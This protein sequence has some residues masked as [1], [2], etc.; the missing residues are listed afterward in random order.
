[1]PECDGYSL[2]VRGTQPPSSQGWLRCGQEVQCVGSVRKVPSTSV[3]RFSIAFKSLRQRSVSVREAGFSKRCV[4]AYG[5]RGVASVDGQSPK[6]VL[7]VAFQKSRRVARTVKLQRMS[8]RLVRTQ[9]SVSMASVSMPSISAPVENCVQNCVRSG[10]VHE[11]SMTSNKSSAWRSLSEVVSD[12][13][14][15]VR[16]PA[17]PVAQRTVASKLN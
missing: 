12:V 1:M 4:V 7:S 17:L 14:R 5:L 10:R 6:G 15:D 3:P 2:F 16:R 13:L 8:R 11:V 9:S